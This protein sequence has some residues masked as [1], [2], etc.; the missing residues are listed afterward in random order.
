MPNVTPS[1]QKVQVRRLEAVV[2]AVHAQLSK[3]DADEEIRSL[4]QSLTHYLMW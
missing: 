3:R 2:A 1:M 4:T